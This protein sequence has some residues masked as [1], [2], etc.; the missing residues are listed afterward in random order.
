MGIEPGLRVLP[1]GIRSEAGVRAESARRPLPYVADHLPAPG[2]GVPFRAGPYIRAAQRACVE[3]GPLG[4]GRRFTPGEAA[5]GA[6]RRIESGCGFPLRLGRQAAPRPATVSHSLM[7]VHV[8]DRPIGLEGYPTV[9]FAPLPTTLLATPVCRLLGFGCGAPHPSLV[10]PQLP[11][12]VAGVTNKGGKLPLGHGAPRDAEGRDHD[13]VRP[14]LVVE[15]EWLAG[16]GPEE[17][18]APHNLYVTQQR[19]RGRSCGQHAG[20]RRGRIAM[21]L[22]RVGESLVVHVLVEDRIESEVE[23]LGVASPMGQAVEDAVSYLRHVGE[24]VL[25][26]RQRQI[27]SRVMSNGCGVPK[28]VAVG[29]DRRFTQGVPKH[30]L[31]LEP[32]YVTNLPEEGVYDREARP[33][34]LGVVE[35]DHEIDRAF[36]RVDDPRREGLGLQHDPYSNPIK[37][38]R[39]SLTRSSIRSY[40]PPVLHIRHR[41]PIMSLPRRSLLGGVAASA[42]AW[43]LAKQGAAAPR[44]ASVALLKARS[45][46]PK[47]AT[48]DRLDEAW[49]RRSIARLQERLQDMGLEG[50]VLSDGWNLIYFTG[51]FHTTTE[52]PFSLW[53]PAKG[54]GL[55]WFHPGL[56]RDLISSWW[57]KE[58][59]T[60]FDLKHARDAFPNKGVVREGDA[61]DLSR[62]L[63]EGLRKRGVANGTVGVDSSITEELRA[64]VSQVVPRVSLKEVGDTCERFRMVKTP[65]EVALTQRSYGYF[66]RI[67]AFARDLILDKGT[68]LTDS[69][70]ATASTRY[71]I[72]L[73][74][75]DI[76]HDGRPHTAVGIEVDI[77][78]RTGPATAYPHPNQFFYK[79][80]E[81]GDALQVA[82][83]VNIGGYGGELY[84]AYQIAPYDTHREKV[85]EVH[86][87]SARLQQEASIAGVSCSHVAKLVHDYQV[88]MG[89][90][91][92]IYHRPGHGEGT[93]GHQPPYIALGDF[94]TLEEGMMFS[95]E[96]GLYD[97]ENGFGYN[98][99]D[100]V[101]VTAKGGVPQ[102]S[103]PLTKEWC[104][105]RL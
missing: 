45:D 48:F 11:A 97:P 90:Q 75:K 105:L 64:V 72:D 70:V 25:A 61:V 79:R 82:G 83:V 92:Y 69:E 65:E 95:N 34:E 21:S 13:W 76:K 40:A 85:W 2:G 9:K 56:D 35:I 28:S 23:Q 62:W 88:K 60:Y 98:H 87:E 73:I 91:K 20:E 18:R 78:C 102:S 57:I 46:H 29:P 30:P 37:R 19:A 50:A 51:L 36:P 8:D 42:A 5:F 100:N 1:V 86:T 54:E 55:C 31:F 77:E 53:V 81:R 84:R 15:Y 68:S 14:L 24:G 7:P 93:E 96:P 59:E 104:L 27:P 47:P 38:D 39:C 3:L 58:A 66:D 71:G 80:V 17:E 49:Y 16:D 101:L 74:M 4:G 52:R 41:R 67:Q 44:A 103:V 32:S 6:C 43:L 99:S 10:G 94:T 89:M 26:G 33:D 22:P 63:W 12:S